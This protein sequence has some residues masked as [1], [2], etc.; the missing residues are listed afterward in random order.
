MVV[1]TAKVK[2]STLQKV[3][4]ANVVAEPDAM[5]ENALNAIKPDLSY[6]TASV[7]VKAGAKNTAHADKVMYIIRT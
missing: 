6:E 4:H 1:P 2:R 3:W 7:T 5:L